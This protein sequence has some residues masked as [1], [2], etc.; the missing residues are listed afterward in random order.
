[1]SDAEITTETPTGHS[2]RTFIK[3]VI[4]TGAVV[5][6]SSHLFRARSLSASATVRAS[7]PRMISLDV[8]G[9]SRSVDVMP[10][11]TLA[12]TLRYKLGLTGTK[13]GCDRA[14]CGACTVLIDG[15]SHYA[16]SLLTNAVRD[17]S[18]TSIEGLES[19]DGTLH[20]VQQ[21][22][23]DEGGFQCAFCA[24]GF[25]MSMVALTNENPE[26]TREEAAEALSGNL[27]R[28]GD[29]N[30]ILNSAMRAAEYARR[31]V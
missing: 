28:C 15:V 7:M 26:P 21:A 14:E 17:R 30:K 8:N 6:S 16:C 31:M 25:I 4:A 1:M 10:Q 5:S 3:G 18:V 12:M 23:I 24:P 22:V 9:T 11:E 2:R 19:A 29:Y 13:L 20:P 27:C